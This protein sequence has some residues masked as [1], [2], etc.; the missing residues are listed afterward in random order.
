M[1]QNV[2][3]ITDK[4]VKDSPVSVAVDC[5]LHSQGSIP[6]KKCFSIPNIYTSSGT[7]PASYLV[8][9]SAFPRG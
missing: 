4:V 3:I 5:R 7:H 2:N 1:Q 8:G 9:A 6:C